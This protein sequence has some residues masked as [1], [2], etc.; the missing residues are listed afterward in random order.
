MPFI[1]WHLAQ[2]GHVKGEGVAAA[3]DAAAAVDAVLDPAHAAEEAVLAQDG[4]LVRKDF[5]FGSKINTV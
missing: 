3:A 2:H 5:F 4:C 1:G